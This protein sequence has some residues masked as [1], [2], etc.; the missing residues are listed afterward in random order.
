MLMPANS[1][2]PAAVPLCFAHGNNQGGC[3]MSELPPPGWYQNPSGDGFRYWDG[4]NWTDRA[5]VPSVQAHNT[6]APPQPVKKN[7]LG[8]A[9]LC[10]AVIA[11][12]VAIVAI[13]CS[14]GHTTT[15]GKEESVIR[16][17]QDAAKRGLK[18]PDSARFSDWTA[19]ATSSTRSLKVDHVPQNGD[20][21]YQ[22]SG[23]INAKNSFGG[24]NGD[25]SYQ[26]DAVVSTDGNTYAAAWPLVGD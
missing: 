18:D 17:C 5:S 12:I 21:V 11:A 23:N 24:Y 16:A 13:S 10:C 22:A 2:H 26:C 25:R 4:H 3:L 1:G 9:I 6:H 20:T 8:V 7:Y 19:T 15:T 14:G